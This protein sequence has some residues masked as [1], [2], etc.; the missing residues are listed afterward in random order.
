MYRVSLQ[1]IY[2]YSQSMLITLEISSSIYALLAH[3][4]LVNPFKL[5][6]TPI[7]MSYT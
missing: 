4:D 7:V 1:Y 6:L 3:F 5:K 2:I